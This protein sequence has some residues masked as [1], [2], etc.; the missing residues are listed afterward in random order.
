MLYGYAASV[1]QS[2]APGGFDYS[3][4]GRATGR[5]A[6]YT[7]IGMAVIVGIAYFLSKR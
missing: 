6:I 7:I 3:L 4:H 5:Q 2:N 1:P